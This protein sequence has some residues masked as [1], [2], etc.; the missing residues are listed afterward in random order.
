MEMLSNAIA[1]NFGIMTEHDGRG[2]PM[3]GSVTCVI[4]VHVDVNDT[5]NMPF[6]TLRALFDMANVVTRDKIK[7]VKID[8]WLDDSRSDVVCSY[9][10]Q[11][12][13][14]HFN[15]SS[16]GEANHVLTMS[17]QPALA[18]NQFMKLDMSN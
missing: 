13:I 5:V 11:G 6:T 12:W 3:M 8:F 16:S 1:T 14:S 15:V 10:F 7:D 17:L 18:A 4:D 2:M 9:A